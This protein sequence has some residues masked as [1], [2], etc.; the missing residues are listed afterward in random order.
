[1]CNI[2]NINIQMIIFFSKS[3]LQVTPNEKENNVYRDPMN[4]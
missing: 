3:Q 1:M 4:L 2:S